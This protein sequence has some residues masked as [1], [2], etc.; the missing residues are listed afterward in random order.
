MRADPYDQSSLAA[1]LISV[2]GEQ[3]LVDALD[4]LSESWQHASSYF[5][6]RVNE[7]HY[8]EALL[9]RAWQ[10]HFAQIRTR[11]EALKAFKRLTLNL[12]S[13]QVTAAVE[14]QRQIGST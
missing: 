8:F 14:I 13:L 1:F 6:K 11:P 3:L 9:Q 10:K 2:A 5:W 12:A 4:W 7:H